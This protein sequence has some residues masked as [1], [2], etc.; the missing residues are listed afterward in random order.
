M[1]KVKQGTEQAHGIG[2]DGYEEEDEAQKTAKK[3]HAREY[4]YEEDKS[5]SDSNDEGGVHKASGDLAQAI[6]NAH[7]ATALATSKAASTATQQLPRSTI[8]PLIPIC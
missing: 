5:D 6:A 8:A 3:A 1:A 4:G 7:A 2:Y